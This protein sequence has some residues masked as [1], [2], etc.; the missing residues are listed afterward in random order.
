MEAKVNRIKVRGYVT[1]SNLPESDFVINP[2]VGCLHGCKYCYASFMKRFTGHTE[3]WGTFIDIKDC[4][5]EFEVKNLKGKTIFISSVTD[6][7]NPIEKETELTR[8]ILKEL[9][10]VDAKI[11]ITTKSSLVLR[12]MDIIKQLNNVQVAISINTLDENFKNDM[13]NASPIKDRIETLKTL[14]E[15][16]I[17]TVLFMSPIFPEITNFKEIINATKEYVDE[18]W[19]EDL[20]LRGEYKKVILDYIS[21]KYP[22]L[23]L[24]YRRIYV[25]NDKSYWLQLA[26]E[27][28]LFCEKNSINFKNYFHHSEIKK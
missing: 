18:Y 2:Y 20:N 5:N 16:G 23:T 22:R 25:K 13:D 21:K 26:K 17:K 14:H 11:D 7:Y 3:D 19:F 27:I 9:I 8:S 1:K 12:D 28:N 4:D 15:N 6:C 24:L 10:G